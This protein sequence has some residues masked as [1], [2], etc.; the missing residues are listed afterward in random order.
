MKKRWLALAFKISWV[1]DCWSI[2]LY[3]LFFSLSKRYQR[4][5]KTR[6][7]IVSTD[8]LVSWFGN[9]FKIFHRWVD[10]VH[11]NTS[12]SSAQLKSS[13][14]YLVRSHNVQVRTVERSGRSPAQNR[15]YYSQR[16]RV[17][18][19]ILSYRH[20]EL[21]H[22]WVREEA[23]GRYVLLECSNLGNILSIW[24]YFNPVLS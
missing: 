22:G 14:T 12:V 6:A 10:Y 16:S 18:R 1:F 21:R 4:C 20:Y 15:Q 3:F 13:R 7:S 9:F 17:Q 5:V 2:L 8:V 11:I 19:L 24:R 23:N